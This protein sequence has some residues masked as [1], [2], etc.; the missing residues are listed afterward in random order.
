[1][2]SRSVAALA[3]GARGSADI[4]GFSP[5]VVRVAGGFGVGHRKKDTACGSVGLIQGPQLRYN[6]GLGT[7]LCRTAL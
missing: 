7:K 3:E 1:M 6:L 2:A 4:D 5:G